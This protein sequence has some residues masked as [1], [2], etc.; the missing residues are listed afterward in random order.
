MRKQSRNG[1]MPYKVEEVLEFLKEPKSRKEIE[2]KFGLSNSESWHLVK[3]LEKGGYIEDLGNI[4]I[5]GQPNR[6]KLYKTK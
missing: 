5:A 1:K 4:P 3:W 2:E 6:I